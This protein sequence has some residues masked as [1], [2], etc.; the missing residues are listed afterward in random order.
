MF[1]IEIPIK[2][3][4]KSTEVLGV[5][6]HKLVF[7]NRTAGII[8]PDNETL[9]KYDNTTLDLTY[10]SVGMSEKVVILKKL[11]YNKKRAEFTFIIE[12]AK[13][14]IPILGIVGAVSVIGV[15][16]LVFVKGSQIIYIP[17]M[18]VLGATAVYFY[19]KLS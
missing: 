14:P 15:V 12:I 18:A 1:D 8:D 11:R 7:K 4:E 6:T 16:A 10:I 2:R 5:G 3:Y 17:A 9:K 19:D 13:N